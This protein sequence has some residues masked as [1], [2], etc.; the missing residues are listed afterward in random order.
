[1][2]HSPTPVPAILPYADLPARYGIQFPLKLTFARAAVYDVQYVAHSGNLVVRIHGS[3]MLEIRPSRDPRVL[4]WIAQE[5][6]RALG[7]PT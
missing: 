5:L 3:E 6:R 1:L 7:L 2:N 4:T